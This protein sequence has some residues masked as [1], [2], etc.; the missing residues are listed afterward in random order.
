M[1]TLSD[2]EVIEAQP[3]TEVAYQKAFARTT[4]IARATLEGLTNPT[5]DWAA[6]H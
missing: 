4:P 1:R 3:R 6:G 2:N 5:H